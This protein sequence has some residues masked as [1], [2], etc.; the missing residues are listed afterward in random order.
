MRD[1]WGEGWHNLALDF[2]KFRVYY[3]FKVKESLNFLCV[4]L[5]RSRINSEE[6]E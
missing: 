2:G 5:G 1:W 4:P 6:A 3:Y